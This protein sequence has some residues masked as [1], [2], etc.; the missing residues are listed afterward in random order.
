MV[1]PKPKPRPVPVSLAP[2]GPIPPHA[3]AQV[4]ARNL[5]PLAGILLFGWSAT[6]I[7]LLY[8]VD[9]LLALAVILAGVLRHLSPV[10]EDDGWAARL[11]GEAGTVAGGLFAAAFLA[12][13]L[14]VPLVFM[15]DGMPNLRQVFADPGFR[16]GLVG[17]VVAAGWSYLGL[18]RALRTATP[19]Q[20]RLRQR[21]G[22]VLLRWL[23]LLPV[24]YLGV[25]L[26]AGRHAA[27]LFVAVYTV[28]MIWSE[29][30]PDR[31]LR[32]MP[33]GE[34]NLRPGPE[35]DAPR[36]LPGASTPATPASGATRAASRP[37][38]R[39]SRRAPRSG[40]RR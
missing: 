23:A 8:F 32:A 28:L 27:L 39:T 13:P 11:N 40:R 31:F 19:N 36:A 9:T 26:A 1:A 5:V 12:V 3:I 37:A 10:P 20:L 21:F 22:L 29:L 7:L 18:Y 6:S 25:G 24:A 33:G 35:L 2:P 38:A 34:E 17:Q 4:V 15:L 30:M 14:G 16:A